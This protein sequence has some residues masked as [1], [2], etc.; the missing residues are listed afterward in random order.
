M[1]GG[2]PAHPR[3]PEA[4]WAAIVELRDVRGDVAAGVVE[5]RAHRARRRRG[6][7]PMRGRLRH[8]AFVRM[9]LDRRVVIDRDE[10]HPVHVEQFFQL[11]RDAQLV[12]AVARPQLLLAEPYVLDGI[13][14]VESAVREAV[15]HFAAA[16]EVGDEGEALAVP[17]V[18]IRTGRWLAV[19]LHDLHRRRLRLRRF[20]LHGPRRPDHPDRVGGGT[21]AEPEDDV[22]GPQRRGDGRRLDLLV[23]AARAHVHLGADAAAVAHEAL[24]LHAQR[25]V[26]AAAVVAQD[27]RRP[28]LVQGDDVGV[29]VAVQVAGRD[30]ADGASRDHRRRDFAEC[31]ADIAEE[32]QPLDAGHQQVEQAVVVVIEELRLSG[33]ARRRRRD[34]LVA[35]A[36]AAQR[37]AG[38][39][40]G[41]EEEI[42]KAVLVDVGRR[43][44][45]GR[46]TAQPLRRRDVAKGPVPLVLE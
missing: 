21:L 25:V 3:Q 32:P 5:G 26:A 8:H 33:A 20:G 6:E 39:L 44:D 28:L 19:E 9:Y 7:Q 4:C 10:P 34:D 22:G 40:A 18:E 17:G 43:G 35:P 2:V 38:M 31:F 12:A 23:Q 14:H 36:P 37:E 11:V 30:E 46:D 1:I 15:P 42:R 13:G 27:V 24:E 29:A 45:Q 16:H 41:R